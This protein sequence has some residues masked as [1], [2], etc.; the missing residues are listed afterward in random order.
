LFVTSI[1]EEMERRF[2]EPSSEPRDLVLGF[3]SA[4]IEKYADP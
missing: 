3:L 2:A 1:F 4:W